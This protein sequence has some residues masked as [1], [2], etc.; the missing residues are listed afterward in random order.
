MK[1]V[2]V[3][4]LAMTGLV[5]LSVG[6]ASAAGFA[7]IEQSV[8][9]LGNS[10]AGGAAVADDATTIYFNPAG[11]SRLEGMN[12]TAGLHVIM[13]SAKFTATSATNP[14]GGDISTAPSGGDGGEAAVVPNFYFAAQA[15]EKF[16]YG[17]S[18]NTPFGMATKY[19]ND[20]VGRYHAIESELM[21]ININPSASYKINDNLSLG[22]GVSA[23]YLDATLSQ[24]QY[25]GAT[26]GYAE[27][28]GD[29]WG[30]GFNV[31][32]LYEVNSDTRIGASYRSSVFHSVDG[33]MSLTNAGPYSGTGDTAGKIR[34][35][36]SAQASVFHRLNDKFDV[37]AD[38][39]W[40]EWSVFEQLTFSKP[41]ALGGGV[42][43]TD[44]N[45]KDN[46]RYSLGGTYHHN[47]A[48][49]F[50]AG[51]A[52]DE[53]PIPDETRT[54]RIPGA[55]RTWVSLGVSYAIN[56]MTFDFAYAHLFVDDGAIN[57]TDMA[58]GRGALVGSFANK[59]DIV[60][61][62]ASYKF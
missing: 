34:L 29:S 52:Y 55:D 16:S 27:V 17:L 23:Q 62:E 43:I 58:A 32:A 11:M 22:L 26:D 28:T 46:M 4:L 44:E 53:T 5:V 39:M 8:K 59:V 61:V 50:R 15:N 49:A 40:T 48:L 18:I 36:A 30:Y 19:D 41:A 51:V 12:A 38:V 37:M 20:W 54:P 42:S 9:G 31:G 57:L 1:R 10:F 21:T 24:A 6:A 2:V 33:T 14:V 13:P 25:L 47:D 45:W 7:L 3:L 35:P 56:N 60:S